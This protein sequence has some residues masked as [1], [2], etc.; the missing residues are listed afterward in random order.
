MTLPGH[1]ETQY[2]IK[3]RANHLAGDDKLSLLCIPAAHIFRNLQ[4]ASGLHL[5][6]RQTIW[7]GG[8]DD[9]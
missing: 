7:T 3:K 2:Q 6:M 9:N 8:N 5:G 4:A 1:I